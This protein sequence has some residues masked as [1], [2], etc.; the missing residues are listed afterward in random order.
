MSHWT[1]QKEAQGA[2]VGTVLEVSGAV[3]GFSTSNKALDADSI[4]VELVGVELPDEDGSVYKVV[5]ANTL[6]DR[7]NERFSKPYLDELARDLN[8]KGGRTYNLFHAQAIPIGKVLPTAKVMPMPSKPGEWQLEG[9]TWVDGK[10]VIPAQPEISVARAIKTGTLSDV[11]VEVRGSIRFVEGG[12]WEWFVDPERPGMAEMVGLALVPQGAQKETQASVKSLD[13][14]TKKDNP[15]IMSYKD[16]FFI[17]DKEYAVEMQQDGTLK[18]IAEIVADYKAASKE[19]AEHK[20]KAASLEA[21]IAPVRDALKTEITALS[22]LTGDTA[23]KSE[24]LDKL[25]L[26]DLHGKAVDLRKK[27]DDAADTT[28]KSENQA[29]KPAYKIS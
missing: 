21:E 11:S 16:K 4:K 27:H 20:A 26:K 13:G 2:T 6:L 24:D 12:T 19:V 5:M 9:H 7:H 18:G 23:P 8:A 22:V 3:F 15:T 17:S 14:G 10:A 1:S 29:G 25:T 28:K